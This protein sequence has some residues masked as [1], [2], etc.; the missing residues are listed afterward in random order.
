LVWEDGGVFRHSG[1][2]SSAGGRPLS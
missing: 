2:I 1:I